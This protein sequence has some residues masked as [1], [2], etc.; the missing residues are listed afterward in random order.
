MTLSGKYKIGDR[1]RIPD[2]TFAG[3]IGEVVGHH[4]RKTY[5]VVRLIVFNREVDVPY[6]ES[7]LEQVPSPP[8]S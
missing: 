6:H 1:V 5:T 3:Q 7:Q 4:W 8:E 2:G